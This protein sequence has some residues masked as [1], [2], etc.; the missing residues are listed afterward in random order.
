MGGYR[1]E[2]MIAVFFRAAVVCAVFVLSRKMIRQGH[3]ELFTEAG[4]QLEK[5]E[6]IEVI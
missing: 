5:E 6:E 2:Q 3:Y 4:E 1:I